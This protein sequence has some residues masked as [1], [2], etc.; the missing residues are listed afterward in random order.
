MKIYEL[1]ADF[2]SFKYYLPAEDSKV[3]KL[4]HTFDGRCLSNEWYPYEF[5]VYH[6]KNKLERLRREDFNISHFTLGLLLVSGKIKEVIAKE[7]IEQVEFLP[8]TTSDNREFYFVNVVNVKNSIAADSW[9]DFNKMDFNRCYEF[10]SINESDRVFRDKTYSVNYF[11]T[12]P[13]AN[14]LEEIGIKGCKLR[15]VGEI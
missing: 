7:L 8:V 12:E 9:E 1:E 14:Y 13:F 10:H 15:C 6:G 4:L 2:K 3:I 5:K 11:I